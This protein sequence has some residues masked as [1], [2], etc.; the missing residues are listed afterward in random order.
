ML[1][2]P[3]D[4]SEKPLGKGRGQHGRQRWLA[5][6]LPTC[7]AK[8]FGQHVFQASW[9]PVSFLRPTG[10]GKTA[11]YNVSRPSTV[12]VALHAQEEGYANY[13]TASRSLQAFQQEPTQEGSQDGKLCIQG[14][15]LGFE[16]GR[17]RRM[18]TLHPRFRPWLLG[19]QKT[20]NAN[21]ASKVQAL[22]FG[23]AGRRM[24]TLYPRFRL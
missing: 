22:T 3:N 10:A 7:P 1:N 8:Q 11:I 19:R 23:E 13:P 2:T 15:G 17:R 20:Q 16:T 21:F 12:A 14:L 4:M 9:C 6:K 18:Q 5:K 24:Q